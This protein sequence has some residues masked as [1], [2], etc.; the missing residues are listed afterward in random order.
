MKPM[1]IISACSG[2]LALQKANTIDKN[3]MRKYFGLTQNEALS[4][5]SLINMF[6]CEDADFSCFNGYYVGYSIAQTSKEFDLLR[7]S[8]DLIIN[9]E[10]KGALEKEEVYQKVNDQ[11]VENYYYLKFLSKKIIIFT[12]V[13]NDGFYRYN[14][15]NQKSEKAYPMELIECLLHQ[16]VNYT[17]NPTD[18]FVPSNYLISPFNNTDKFINGEFFLTDHQRNIKNEIMTYL[19]KNEFKIFC[20][21]AN[22]GT[23]KTLLLYDI[24]RSFIQDSKTPL[25]IHSGILNSGHDRLKDCGWN[26][27][28]ISDLRKN[29]VGRLINDSISVVIIDEAQRVYESQIKHLVNRAIEL[30]ISLLF[31]YDIKQF[32]RTSE[33][34]DIFKYIEHNYKKVT[35]LEYKL[36]NKIRTNKELASFIQNLFTIGKSKDYLNYE[37]VS[38]EYFDERDEVIQYITSL[39]ET[40]G[41]KAITYTSSMYN[42]ESIDSLS[43]ICDTKAHSVIGQEFKKVVFVMDSNF[44][45][46]E[47]GKLETTRN[48]Y[49]AFGM[50]YQIVTRVVDE[51]KI[52]V[53]DNPN[54]VIKLLEI[55]NNI[56]KEK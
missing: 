42:Y 28:P 23:G 31:S 3:T 24:A 19:A 36:T 40:D 17:I 26:I 33:S 18:L 2:M 55:K 1:N 35:V 4:L 29:S 49:S 53:L 47:Q 8:D 32:L 51:L 5:L 21:S 12:Y 54:L 7:F 38:I 13:E 44:R 20:I 14:A 46:N 39:Q 37:N 30:K 56:K 25:I 27:I 10:L 41:W 34:K 22:A 45:Y 9:I 16:K 48:Y 11:M 15:E 52:I 43:E 50:L 6:K